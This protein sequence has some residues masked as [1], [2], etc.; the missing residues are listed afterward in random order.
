[1]YMSLLGNM[2]FINTARTAAY[3]PRLGNKYT[4]DFN[5]FEV[6]DNKFTKAWCRRWG[7][8][9]KMPFDGVEITRERYI[10]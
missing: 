7:N 9:H 2:R 6:V 10:S 3:G 5:A 4:I 1:M 8:L